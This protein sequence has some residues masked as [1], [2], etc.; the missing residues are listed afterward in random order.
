MFNK[1]LQEYCCQQPNCKVSS[2]YKSNITRHIKVVCKTLST[3]KDSKVCPHCK[4]TFPQKSNRDRH[5][6]RFHPKTVPRNDF[7]LING[8]TD[9]EIQVPTFD[10]ETAETLNVSFLS[11]DGSTIIEQSMRVAD[12]ETQIFEVFEPFVRPTADRTNNI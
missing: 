8:N 6:K 9:N 4:E 11:S 12:T 2:K 3:K 10:T 5:V 7:S 1:K